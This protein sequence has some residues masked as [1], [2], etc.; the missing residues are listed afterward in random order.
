[1]AVSVEDRQRYRAILI[2][3]EVKH[4]LCAVPEIFG[5]EPRHLWRWLFLG[6]DGKPHRAGEIILADL[7][8]YARLDRSTIFDADPVTLAYREGKRAAVLRIINYLNL[9][10]QIVQ[11]LMELDDGL[12]T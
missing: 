5:T 8:D 6:R 7:R 9:D 11:Q 1:M 4:V 2:A 10:E 12:D 3:R